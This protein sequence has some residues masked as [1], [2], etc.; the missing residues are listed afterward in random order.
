M[1][2]RLFVSLC[3]PAVVAGLVS[4]SSAAG[5]ADYTATRTFGLPPAGTDS[6]G[7]VLLD[8]LPD[9]RLLAVNGSAAL[10]ETAVGSGTFA[11]LGAVGGYA[12]PSFGG[13]FLTV[14]PDGTRAAVGAN[15]SG[16]VTVFNTATPATATTF[17][18]AQYDFDAAWADNS[19][20]AVSNSAGV[21][22]LNTTTGGATTVVTDVGGASAGV[23]FDAAGNLYTGNG[24]DY[25][26]TS[27]S[28]TGTIKAFSK[29]AWQA[30]LTGG[31]AADFEATG[32]A[33]AKL[34]SAG[35]LGFDKSGN[36]Y[37]GGGDFFGG[38]GDFGYAALVS[39][40][41]VQNALAGGAVVTASSDASALRKFASPAATVSADESP[42]WVYNDAT[43]D[44]DLRYFDESGVTVYGV[45]EPTMLAGVLLG[46][47]AMLR[48][49][50]KT[51]AGVA[52]LAVTAAA[53][54]YVYNP[55][56]FATDVVASTGLTGT[57]L[58]NDPAAVLGRPTLKFNDGTT[59]NP[60]LHRA[61][62][63]EGAYN[64]GPAG[65]KLITTL[66]AGQ[67]ITVKMGHAITDDPSHPYGI[68]FNVF[69]NSFFS[70]GTFTSDDTN[71]NTT[72][73]G[74]IFAESVRVSVSPDNVNWYSYAA[75][76][77]HT[78]DGYFPTNSYR[79]DRASASWS[80]D[81]LDPTKAVNPALRSTLVGMNAADAVDAYAGAAGGAGFDL[82]ESGYESVQYV[83][84]DG[85]TGYSGGEIDAVAAVPEPA[86]LAGF[87]L[88]A[89]GLLRRRR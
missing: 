85:L 26:A 34:L 78:G 20:L 73:L 25:D 6:G 67:S 89:A 56:D 58:Y 80:D 14:S 83:R 38:S 57:G 66:N 47:L 74:G 31:T 65:E 70:P 7:N 49:R 50:R 51:I 60:D 29:T 2:R 23:A 40:S 9:G 11:S 68:D 24:Y 75:D 41:A 52:T 28:S 5:I 72:T 27:G 55:N 82:A 32:T 19:R 33:V 54:A 59:A 35:S 13:S 76:A 43:G 86:T 69:G 36:F 62:L 10:V 21:Q 71:L 16:Q 61:K 42:I 84:F 39:A 1:G 63:I 53:Q 45:P 3:V 17:G 77:A 46:G 15:G 79:W 87:G 22:I 37:V 64:T 8:A 30:A 88:I 12:P 18:G 81:E 44:L 48:R 4:V